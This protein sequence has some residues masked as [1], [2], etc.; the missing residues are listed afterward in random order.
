ME[1]NYFQLPHDG[2]ARKQAMIPEIRA[3]F[4]AEFDQRRYDQFNHDINT[5][6]MYPADFKVCET[7]L[8]L[9]AAL[10][11]EL[12][13]ASD[14]VIRAIQSDEYKTRTQNAIPVGYAV[15]N[16]DAHSTFLQLDFAVCQQP[17]GCFTPRLIELQG[18]PSL[19]CFQAFLDRKIR[20]YFDLPAGFSAYFG[21]LDV[22]GYIARLRQVIVADSAPEQVILLEVEPGAQKTRV[23]FAC[24]EQMLGVRAVDIS[25]IKQ[26]GQKLFYQREGREIPIERIYHRIIRDD[27][28]F[29]ALP[30][31]SW[32]RDDLDV[33]WVGHPNWYYK[34]SKYGLPLIQNAYTSDCHYLNDLRA[35]P[36][37]LDNY[38]LK[39]LYLYSGAGV[40]LD[41]T[42]ALLDSL[43]NREN[44]I[45]QRK[46]EYA[47]LVLTPDGYARAEVRMLFVWDGDTPEP[48]G[49]LVR[50]SK[51]RMMGVRFNLGKTWVGSTVAYA[52]Q[53]S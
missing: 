13:T 33:I 38:V 16:E 46:V 28:K 51:G 50:M 3:K 45:L 27:P 25:A 35:Y 20:Q 19:F 24:T 2:I 15:P 41:V 10:R 31:I 9:S 49:N 21:G 17:D 48:I 18:F 7:P 42:P 23:D 30:E 29:Q 22:D 44:Y 4:N 32:L 43:P 40:E 47:P 5:E 8:F 1:T 11:D 26:R 52:P 37:D 39:P 36:T 34:I 53:Y 6:Q 12:L 14:A